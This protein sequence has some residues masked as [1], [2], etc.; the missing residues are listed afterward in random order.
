MTQRLQN[1]DSN[2][3]CCAFHSRVLHVDGSNVSTSCG[4]FSSPKASSTNYSSKTCSK[5]NANGELKYLHAPTFFI[6]FPT[7]F[8]LYLYKRKYV[9]PTCGGELLFRGCLFIH[10]YT[11][12]Q[13]PTS[14]QR[15]ILQFKRKMNRSD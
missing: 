1:N 11:Y 10:D 15:E 12:F 4:P 8:I 14:H 6:N 13:C 5:S 7:N 2:S 3:S 9:D